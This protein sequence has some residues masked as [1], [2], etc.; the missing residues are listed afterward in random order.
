MIILIYLFLLHQAMSTLTLEDTSQLG[1]WLPHTGEGAHMTPNP[2]ILSNVGPY[3]G[4]LY[5]AV[6]NG[7]HLP[8]THVGDTNISLDH[9]S[10]P[11]KNVY[12][13]P[14]LSS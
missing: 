9:Y 10:L 2:C 14:Q 6:G 7:A 3:D 13:V 1:S 11:L 4:S 5:I 8:V 12:V